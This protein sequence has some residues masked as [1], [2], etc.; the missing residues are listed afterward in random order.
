MK[1]KEF[2]SEII[3]EEILDF[4]SQLPIVKACVTQFVEH[5][6]HNIPHLHLKI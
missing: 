1:E 4:I 2:T 6:N 5:M 3:C